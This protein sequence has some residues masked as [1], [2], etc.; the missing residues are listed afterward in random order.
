MKK[1]LLMLVMFIVVLSTI[2]NLSSCKK[3]NDPKPSNNVS[4]CAIAYNTVNYSQDWNMEYIIRPY[5]MV[6]R[7]TLISYG[8]PAS[9]SVN[10]GNQCY[11]N[12]RT[13]SYHL[14]NSD[15]TVVRD[16]DL[17]CPPNDTSY[18]TVQ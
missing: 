13:I 16:F 9:Y 3:K 15:S 4:G 14:W 8:N 6:Y 7:D 2:L 10:A 18:Y 11:P 5:P 17:Y 12:G 1:Q